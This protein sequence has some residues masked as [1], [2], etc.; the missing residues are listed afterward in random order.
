MI[1]IDEN[2]AKTQL[3]D[4]ISQL[5]YAVYLKKRHTTRHYSGTLTSC[6]RSISM[7][8]SF[9]HWLCC[10]AQLMWCLKLTNCL[11]TQSRIYLKFYKLLM[12]ALL[13]FLGD[14]LSIIFRRR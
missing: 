10:H 11:P 14:D 8:D 12:E 6:H 4:T 5:V 3:N 2:E 9:L 1:I 7:D 13:K